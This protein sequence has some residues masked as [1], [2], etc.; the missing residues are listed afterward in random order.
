M[1]SASAWPAGSGGLELRL[2]VACGKRTDGRKGFLR[3]AHCVAVEIVGAVGA[4]RPF[5]RPRTPSPAAASTL[6]L[7]RMDLSLHGLRED[8][9]GAPAQGLGSRPPGEAIEARSHEAARRCRESATVGSSPLATALGR[10]LPE[11]VAES[12]CPEMQEFRLPAANAA[13]SASDRRR[14]RGRGG[15]RP[16]IGVKRWSK[17]EGVAPRALWSLREW[18][19]ATW[20]RRR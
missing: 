9:S 5:A 14:S 11:W 20:L 17:G 15:R 18:L 6:G 12:P 19:P 7:R 3:A 2:G 10:S 16:R 1:N 8:G 13:Y 4:S